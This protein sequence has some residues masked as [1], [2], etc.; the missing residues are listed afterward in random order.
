MTLTPKSGVLDIE[1]YVGGRASVAG[2]ASPI[3]LSSNES[4]LGPSPLGLAA[5]Q[6]AA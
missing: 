1:P 3:K 4:A 2:V 6:E 5:Y